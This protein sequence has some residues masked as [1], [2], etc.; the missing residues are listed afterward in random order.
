MFLTD[1][2]LM[3]TSTFRALGLDT[4][5]DILDEGLA[6]PKFA[7]FLNENGMRRIEGGFEFEPTKLQ[8]ILDVCN[9]ISD[10]YETCDF[11]DPMPTWE[12][13]DLG[14]DDSVDYC[15]GMPTALIECIY[16]ALTGTENFIDLKF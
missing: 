11:P 6:I 14:G 3:D 2:R 10:E 13:F 4:I 5:A 15:S 1:A 8:L 12:Q 16:E 9:R 7:A